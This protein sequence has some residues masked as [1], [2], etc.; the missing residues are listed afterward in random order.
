MLDNLSKKN[1]EKISK[2]LNVNRIS[3]EDGIIVSYLLYKFEKGINLEEIENLEDEILKNVLLD[4]FK[5][6]N[7]FILENQNTFKKEELMEFILFYK[8]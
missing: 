1:T 7:E 8:E 2:V 6:Y 3:K 5:K 4:N